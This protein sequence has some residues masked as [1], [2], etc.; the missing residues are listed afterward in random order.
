MSR[1]NS[2]SPT[3]KTQHILHPLNL[4][5]TKT[6]FSFE[7]AK[8]FTDPQSYSPNK[9]YNLPSTLNRISCSIGIGSRHKAEKPYFI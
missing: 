9:F 1:L 6:V 7:K 2:K 3:S 8:R 4:S 5:K